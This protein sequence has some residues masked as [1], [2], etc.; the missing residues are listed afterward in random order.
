MHVH[1]KLV[2]L[3]ERERAREQERDQYQMLWER[4]K[5]LVFKK[6]KWWD[7][8]GRIMPNIDNKCY[9]VREGERERNSVKL[10]ILSLSHPVPINS[11]L[12]NL[13]VGLSSSNNT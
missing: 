4:E 5:I 2:L 12:Y 7:G 13:C 9:W 6:K 10:V 8:E 1:K 11:D 3:K